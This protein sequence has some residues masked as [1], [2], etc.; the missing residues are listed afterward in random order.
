MDVSFAR[1][2]GFDKMNAWCMKG[3]QPISTLYNF[4]HWYNVSTIHYIN[5]LII[6]KKCASLIATNLGTIINMLSQ[7]LNDG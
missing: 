4:M 3:Q 2:I 7:P 1:L 6:H 5:S